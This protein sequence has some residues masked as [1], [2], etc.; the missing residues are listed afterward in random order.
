MGTSWST[1][2]EEDPVMIAVDLQW[3]GKEMP[4]VFFLPESDKKITYE[5]LL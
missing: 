5:A 1:K 2:N 4:F 3:E